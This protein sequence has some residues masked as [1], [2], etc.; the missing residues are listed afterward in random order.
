[1]DDRR[2]PFGTTG[3]LNV[4]QGGGWVDDVNALHKNATPGA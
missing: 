3:R 2:Q 1:M 4:W